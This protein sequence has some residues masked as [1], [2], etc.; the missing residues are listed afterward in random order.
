MGLISNIFIKSTKD[1]SPICNVDLK[2]YAGIWYEVGR[3]PHS[4]EKGLE[5]VTAD[6]IFQSDGKIQ[7]INTGF[8]NGEK[9][10]T[11]GVAWVPD[12]NCTG[13]LLVSFFWLIKSEYKIILLDEK[14][15]KF[16]VVTGSTMN[17]LWILTRESRISN[18]LYNKLVSYAASK[19]FAVA[20]LIR[21]TQDKN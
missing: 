11:K 9:K 19:G 7:V 3:L 5:N 17:Y 15:Y 6:Y 14:E 4:F 18:E 21:V 16:A 2:R 13:K 8:K 12:K 10:V 1:I 20:K